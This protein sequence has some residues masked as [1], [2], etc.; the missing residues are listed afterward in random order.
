MD[1]RTLTPDISVAPQLDPAELAEAAQRGFK[2]IIDNRP[3]NEG[4]GQPT[5]LEMQAAA[6]ANGLSFHYQ[7]VVSGAITPDDVNAFRALLGAVEG[8]VLAYCRSGT[9]CAMLWSLAQAGS[10][11]AD[12]IIATAARAGYDMSALRRNLI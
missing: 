6:T 3:D 2:T 10:M 4:P 5:A 11:S 9:R 12:D 8:P 7:P 1:I